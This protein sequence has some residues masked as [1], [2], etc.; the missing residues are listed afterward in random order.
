MPFPMLFF[1][2]NHLFNMSL[3]AVLDCFTGCF[4]R[5]S[6][7]LTSPSVLSGMPKV[8]NPLHF[9]KADVVLKGTV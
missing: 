1:M 6:E 8:P 7:T 9:C 5:H 2:P 4:E 3:L